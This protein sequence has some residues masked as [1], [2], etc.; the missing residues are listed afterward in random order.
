M[1]IN[2]IATERNANPPDGRTVLLVEDEA[3]LRRV[4]TRNLAR[5]GYYPIAVDS[6]R[7]AIAEMTMQLPD[8]LLLDINLP[9]RTGWDVL[10]WLRTAH[11]SVVVIICSAVRPPSSM[12]AEF[13]PD[14]V[15]V[16][17][18]AIGFLMDL[19]A[20]A[21]VG[22]QRDTRAGELVR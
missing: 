8:V 21:S 20:T 11:R 7:D 22:N 9:D 10:R 5:R 3:P 16:K 13:R 18:V 1:G 4:I 19:I 2:K 15:V 14:A 6:V 12:L 17:P